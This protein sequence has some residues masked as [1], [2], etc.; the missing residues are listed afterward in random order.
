[1]IIGKAANLPIARQVLGINRHLTS[2]TQ[3]R[4]MAAG[5]AA[6]Q[7]RAQKKGG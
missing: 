7:G 1:M 3:L 6:A 5:D 4:Q 2:H